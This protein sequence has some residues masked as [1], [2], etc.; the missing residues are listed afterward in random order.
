MINNSNIFKKLAYPAIAVLLMGMAKTSHAN[1]ICLTD[2]SR[3]QR[4]D[5]VYRLR[6]VPIPQDIL[7]EVGGMAFLPNDAL[8]V[9][10][11]RGEVW[12]INNPY[13]KNG[14]L[15]VYKLFAQGMHE[16]LGLN[17]IN[18]DVYVVQRSE[19]TRLRDLDGDGEA[20]EYKTMYSWPLAGNY[21]EYAYGPM[22]DKD[23]N[24]VVTLNLGWI[25]FGE[26]LSKWH[27]WMLKFDKD[28]NMKPF[29]AGFRSP[30]AFALN[31]DGDI[32]YSENQGDW[33]GSGN[34]A[35]VAEGDFLGNPRS[36]RWSGEPGSPLKLK[37]EDIPDTGEPKYE[38]AKRIPAL[39][40]PAVWL[41]HTILGIS[42]SGI[43]NYDAKGKM[44]PFEGQMFVGDQGQSKINRVSLEKVKGVYQGVVFP[45]REGFS[46]G[47][48]RLNWG[49]DGSIFA[50]MTSRGW[51]STGKQSYGLQRLEWTGVT[52][53]EVKTI[54]AKPDGFELEFTMPVN[55]SAAKDAASYNISSF[56]YKYHHI[57][58]SPPIM[59]SARVIKA[60]QVSPD[61]MK[62][63]LV[64]DSLKEGYVHEI[65]AEGIR[66]TD[67][68]SLMHNYGYYTLNRIPDGEKLTIT[69][70]NR[71]TVVAKHDHEAMMANAAV[72]A[73]KKPVT[74]SAGKPATATVK[75]LTVQPASWTKGP[76]RTIVLTTR[77]GLKFDI[78]AITVK[79]G[80]KI[81]LTFNNN[82]DM[83]H[84]V[85]VTEPGSAT[86]VG[87]LAIKLGINGERMNYVPNSS[88]VLYH[89]VLLQPNKSESIYFIAPDKPGEY[90]Y[91]C[92]YPGHYMVMRGVMKVEK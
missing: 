44:G 8:A 43:L 29:A 63:R 32:F 48:L 87:Q 69:D 2:T 13:M 59:Q 6:D 57:Y 77:P 50:G 82:D 56:N 54:K 72:A 39:K 80:S 61:K 38:V 60:I 58:G 55:E 91:L 31:N 52:P 81:K 79:A 19:L 41:P 26:S 17:Y 4:E 70:A 83:L 18:G 35:H 30:A 36:L 89:T 1:N 23:G 20:D 14:N 37:I 86:E 65:K 68:L 85:V 71:V 10:T 47:I 25:N 51:G 5:E 34:I 16:V 9:S 24:M 22:L 53:F 40:T 11:R 15:P 84:N 33:V 76:D 67:N 73:N 42:T 27:G 66:S 3:I 88:K 92:S 49:S 74:A 28:F 45:F 46:S 62:V 64:L 75:R 78:E 21:H 12:I 90:E 7:L